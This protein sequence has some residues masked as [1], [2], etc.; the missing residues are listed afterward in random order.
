VSNLREDDL[1]SGA[2][3]SNGE[4]YFICLCRAETKKVKAQMKFNSWGV[5]GEEGGGWRKVCRAACI[6]WM[7]AWYVVL[8]DR[9]GQH[10]QAS[11][12]SP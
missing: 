1:M 5:L 11:V 12:G 6:P 3:D 7:P 8:F 9:Q 10:G 2:A 4:K